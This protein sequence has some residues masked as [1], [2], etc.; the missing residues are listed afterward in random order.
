ME[1]VCRE[2]TQETGAEKAEAEEQ[3]RQ[4]QQAREALEEERR[5]LQTAEVWREER[6]QMK[7]GEARLAL[8]TKSVALDAMRIE[9][10]AFLASQRDGRPYDIT[11]LGNAQ[12]LHKVLSTVHYDTSIS[13]FP[14][15]SSISSISSTSSF[16]P[17]SDLMYA[18]PL[19]TDSS[20]G[21]RNRAYGRLFY[22]EGIPDAD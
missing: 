4:A 2:L 19:D 10:E 17:T 8:E 14:P 12:V 9:L 1:E 20:Q 11:T 21:S 6:V 15:T 3:K 5:M 22:P 16:P 13:T 7:L 18:T